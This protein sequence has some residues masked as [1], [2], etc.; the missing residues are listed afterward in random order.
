MSE[1]SS[2]YEDTNFED[3]YDDD[4]NEFDETED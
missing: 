2:D 1:P 4:L 3:D